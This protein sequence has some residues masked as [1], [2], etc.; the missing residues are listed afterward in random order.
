[1]MKND[2][3]ALNVLTD[4]EI[5]NLIQLST[6]KNVR[7]SEYDTKQP[8]QTNFNLNI[9]ENPDSIIK[10]AQ[11]KYK[12]MKTYFVD[13]FTN[14]KFKGNPAAVCIVESDLNNATMQSIASEIGFSETAF[15][16]QITGN[17]YSI[18]FFTP[19][20]VQFY[21]FYY[22][23]PKGKEELELIRFDG[24]AITKYEKK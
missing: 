16:K 24:Y 14:Q 15:I 4:D 8:H 9:I 10:N 18:R 5:G 12:E 1:M 3:K 23:V 19:K 17:T 13:S 22:N 20:V 21:N 2:L 11:K 7:G 6:K